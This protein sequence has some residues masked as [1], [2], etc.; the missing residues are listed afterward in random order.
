M[1]SGGMIVMDEESCMVDIAKYFLEFTHHESCGKCVPCRMGSQHLLRMLKEITSG[2]GSPDM[3]NQLEQLAETIKS[4]SLCG[5]GQTIPNSILS[6]IQYFRKELEDHL[7]KKQCEAM[8]CKGIISSPC[9]YTCPIGQDVPTYIAHIANE[10]FDRAI[11]IIRREN[12]FP[13]ICGRVCPH[14]CEKNCEAGKHDKPIAIRSLKR[15]AADYE[16]KKGLMPEMAEVKYEEKIAIIGAGPAG[17]AAAWFLTQEGY[18]CTVYEKLDVAGGML[19]VGIPD[20]RLPESILK[21]EI[22]YI[23]KAGVTIK[24]GMSLG[25]DFSIESLKA[26]GYKAIFVATGAHQATPLRIEGEE[27]RAVIPGVSFLRDINLGKEVKIGNRIAVIGGGNVAVDSARAAR[28]MG[29][30]DVFILYRRTQEEM[31]AHMEEIQ[32]LKD[33]KIPVEFL[34]APVKVVELNG[35]FQGIECVKM[36]LAEP[37]S[38]GRRRPVPI[39]GS[40][41][42]LE[43]DNVIS[44][45][46][47]RSELDGIDDTGI[48]ISK[49][50]TIDADLELFST[51]MEGV[52]AGGDV[53]SGPDTVINAIAHGKTAARS[54]GQYLQGQEIKAEYA[55]VRPAECIAPVELTDD[56]ATSLAR[57]K[58]P[59]VAGKKR[60][61]SFIEVEKGFTSKMAVVEAKRCLR[62]DSE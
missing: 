54:I 42:T 47:Q 25:S 19:A 30:E 41:Y 4:G 34:A 58:M 62:C 44:A 43:C 57:P 3:L 45:I 35:R 40:E 2:Q 49:W 22:D 55:P 20:Y 33:E 21:Y 1:G 5:L 39:Q 50:G 18:E 11:E 36:E 7:V 48:D 15:F 24:T 38:S 51:S 8:V 56:E 32:Q 23:K 31:P 10:N 6:T 9:Q 13:G 28:R 52:F 17:L 59:C 53:V 12:P 14:E 37:D 27:N 61:D 26:E 60:V 16:M 46:G 29:S